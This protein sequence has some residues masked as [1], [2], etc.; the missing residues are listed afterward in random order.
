MCEHFLVE[1]NI[2]LNTIKRLGQL[3]S[4]KFFSN[5]RNGF[6]KY[7]FKNTKNS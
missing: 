2:N 7:T 4:R 3:I 1:D 6:N 5:I